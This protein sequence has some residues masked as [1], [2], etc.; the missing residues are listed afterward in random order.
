MQKEKNFLGVEI[1]SLLEEQLH[2]QET[3]SLSVEA[4]VIVSSS[5]PPLICL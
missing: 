2:V 3:I 1:A 4:A 5:P